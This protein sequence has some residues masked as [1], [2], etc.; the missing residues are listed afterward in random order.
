M[1]W[2]G[3]GCAVVLLGIRY[4]GWWLWR[5]GFWYLFG[6]V[7]I[8]WFGGLV[9]FM[10]LCDLVFCLVLLLGVRC[11]CWSG[12][13]WVCVNSVDL[14]FYFYYLVVWLVVCSCDVYWLLQYVAAFCVYSLM[15]YYCDFGVVWLFLVGYVLGLLVCGLVGA[16]CTS[17]VFGFRGWRFCC[18]VFVGA[19]CCDWLLELLFSVCA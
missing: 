10:V 4:C 3:S 12:G 9:G 17:L 5:C 18:F 16:L 1:L 6:F 7:C 2:F 13:L 19:G 11:G 15:V 14:V 8:G